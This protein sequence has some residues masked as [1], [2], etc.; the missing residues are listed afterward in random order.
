M[1]PSYLVKDY[2]QYIYI[3]AL[4]DKTQTSYI[5]ELNDQNASFVGFLNCLLYCPLI[6]LHFRQ[7]VVFIK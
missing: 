2:I 6:I 4:E 7:K 5:Y 3:Y 1:E